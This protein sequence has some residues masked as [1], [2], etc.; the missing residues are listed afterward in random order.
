MPEWQDEGKEED[1]KRKVRDK[2]LDP[3]F[4]GPISLAAVR[5]VTL[6]PESVTPVVYTSLIAMDRLFFE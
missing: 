5:G 1:K 2:T 6:P 4:N 3:V